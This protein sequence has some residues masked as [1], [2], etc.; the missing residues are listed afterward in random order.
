MNLPSFIQKLLDFLFGGFVH[1]EIV[2]P[3]EP[4]KRKKSVNK[5]SL[6]LK[7]VR[8]VKK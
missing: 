3:P 4:V 5:A 7:K 2:T 8:K 1:N 6:K